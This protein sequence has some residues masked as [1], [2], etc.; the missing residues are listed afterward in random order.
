MG[1]NDIFCYFFSHRLPRQ[2]SIFQYISG[3][4]FSLGGVSEIPN[5]RKAKKA[6]AIRLLKFFSP[7]PS[8]DHLQVDHENAFEIYFAGIDDGRQFAH[9]RLL[10]GQLWDGPQWQTTRVGSGGLDPLHWRGLTWNTSWKYFHNL[11]IEVVMCCFKN[12]WCFCLSVF[13]FS[14]S[15]RICAHFQ[16]RLLDAMRPRE[17]NLTASERARN[18][19]SEHLCY[20]TRPRAPFPDYPTSLPGVFSDIVGCRA[21]WVERTY[22]WVWPLALFLVASWLELIN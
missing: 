14:E 2:D 18:C 9:L 4:K 3:M 19:H 20:T 10:P 6:M 21:V 11:S 17:R 1:I 15:F 12:T 16:K 13:K 5:S 7:S 8:C 22:L